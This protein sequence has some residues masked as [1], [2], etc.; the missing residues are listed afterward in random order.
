MS[1]RIFTA[2]DFPTVQSLANWLRDA[3]ID[4][5]SWECGEA[6]GVTSLWHELQR[7]EIT[8]TLKPPQRNMRVVALLIE[9]NDHLLMEV[10]Q[11]MRDG[12][13]RSRDIPPSEKLSADETVIDGAYRCLQEELDIDDK[14]IDICQCHMQETIQESQS[15]PGMMT[16]YAM[17]YVTLTLPHLPEH[18]FVIN[19]HA[20]EDEMLSH[21]W[22]W[23]P[24][25]P[26]YQF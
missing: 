22:G 20:S 2:T 21:T 16:Q 14:N 12:R 11:Q 8:L 7:G 13:I 17:H 3:G 5:D 25:Q 9:R 24:R 6:K 26:R 4:I 18:D 1:N 10:S 15:Y 19:N 23:R